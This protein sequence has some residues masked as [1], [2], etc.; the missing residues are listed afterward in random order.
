MAKP[1]FVTLADALVAPAEAIE[2][3]FEK[4]GYT[5]T[6]EPA[7]LDYPYT[8]TL[9][10]KRNRTTIA[11]DVDSSIRI[12]RVSEWARYGRSRSFDFRVA[13]ATP[14]AGRDLAIEEAARAEKA[15]VY[16]IGDSITEVCAP[17][18]L[19][20]NLDPPELGDMSRK[21]KRALGPMYEQ[22]ERSHWREGLES[23][24]QALESECRKYLQQGIAGGRLVVL[25]KVG[26]R[27]HL[28][29]KSIDGMTLGRLA[30][31][32]S[33]IQTP[34]QADTAIGRVLAEINPH[35]VAVAHHKTTPR[36]E[37][38]LRKHVGK[39]VWLIV[40]GLRKIFDES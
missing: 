17:H 4:M 22:F 33:Q 8:P 21:M 31:T 3:Y 29:D 1:E 24:C 36:T 2:A 40:A 25:D 14:V 12:S 13:A 30:V 19:S 26:R 20:I 32:F 39:A 15:G 23:G 6:R 27:R 34:N 16:L 35:R 9:R 37:A 11:V 28:T 38:K 18:D 7:A 5:V 10:C